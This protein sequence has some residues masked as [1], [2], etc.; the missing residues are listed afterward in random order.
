M[1]IFNGC[2]PNELCN[3]VWKVTSRLPNY[4]PECG[5]K[6]FKSDKEIMIA[7]PQEFDI[8]TYEE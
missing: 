4:C 8:L 1:K 5:T 2:C 3:F 7:K 6:L